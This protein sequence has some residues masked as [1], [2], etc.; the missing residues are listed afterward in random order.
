MKCISILISV[1]CLYEYSKCAP[2]EPINKILVQKFENNID[3]YKFQYYIDDGQQREESGV[4]QNAGSD[5]EN[6]EVQGVFSY[7]LDD[8]R[9]YKV[10]YTAGADGFRPKIEIGFPPA[11]APIPSSAIATL[12]GG[13]G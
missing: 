1:F 7:N 12:T 11:G 2:L 3:N 4:L 13:I 10:I 9:L 6:L 8:G 5:N